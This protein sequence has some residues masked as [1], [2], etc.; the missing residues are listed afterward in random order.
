MLGD[1]GTANFIQTGGTNSDANWFIMSDRVGSNSTYSLS[2]N[3]L[4]FAGEEYIAE[5]GTVTFNQSGGTN[6]AGALS[7][8]G[9]RRRRDLH[10]N[11]RFR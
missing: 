9:H 4:L 10:S 5:V 3:S 7:R 6:A 2:G 8:F 1:S 11:R